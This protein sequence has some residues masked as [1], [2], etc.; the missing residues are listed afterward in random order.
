MGIV[1]PA[2]KSFLISVSGSNKA[3][4]NRLASCVISASVGGAIITAPIALPAAV[5]QIGGYLA[6]AGGIASAVSQVTTSSDDQQK[7]EEQ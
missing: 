4:A 5:V 2:S 1:I 6:V 7:K 3:A